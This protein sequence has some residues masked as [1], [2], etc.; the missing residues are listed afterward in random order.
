MNITVQR[1]LIL[2]AALLTLAGGCRTAFMRPA[3]PTAS[4]APPK[5]FV[6]T[7]RTAP[8][9]DLK[10]YGDHP[11]AQLGEYENRLLT[12]VTR[13]TFSSVGRDFDP[14][15]HPSGEFMLFS[16]TRNSKRPDIF[17]KHVDGYAITQITSDPADDIQPRF[18]PDGD[19]IVFCSN[20]TGNWDVWVVSRDG[21]GLTQLT[22]DR[23]DEIAPCFSP[24]GRSVAFTMWGKRSHQWEIWVL[25]IDSPGVRRFLAYGMFPAWS[26]DG[27][28]IAFQRARQRGTRWFS[29]WT[30]ELVGDE[31]RHPTEVAYSDAAACIAPRWTRDGSALVYCAARQVAGRFEQREQ[32]LADVWQ[33]DVA[34]GV[35]RK[36]TDSA[37][38]AF[39]PTVSPSGRVYF[40]SS[41]AG[42]ENVWSLQTMPSAATVSANAA[43]TAARV[44]R[45]ESTEE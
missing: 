30:I 31:A 28:R 39:N 29:V 22:H 23:T 8:P 12:N 43:S 42:T 20:R 25:A 17:L 19:K 34:T 11:D 5:S 3:P 15:L 45:T 4:E 6:P 1:N 16:S 21:T 27:Q 9:E 41:R 37:A 10:P 32:V 18:S 14:D 13:H 36:L 44:T 26:P 7:N 2:A 24:D 40:V 33:V 38:P 35:R